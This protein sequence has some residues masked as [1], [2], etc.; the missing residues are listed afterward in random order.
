MLRAHGR[1][2]AAMPC[3][4]ARRR[5]EPRAGMPGLHVCIRETLTRACSRWA[6]PPCSTPPAM[7]CH[8]TQPSACVPMRHPSLI[9]ARPH[10]PA[11]SPH[12]A[13]VPMRPHAPPIADRCTIPS[14]RMHAAT[15]CTP[16]AQQHATKRTHTRNPMRPNALLVVP[17][18]L[19]TCPQPRRARCLH[20]VSKT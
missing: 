14:A 2:G 19:I 1:L 20:S 17:S 12:A 15:P 18:P 4:A 5:R 16:R 7:T 8:A 11:R 9:A 10:P 13:C 3:H 6:P